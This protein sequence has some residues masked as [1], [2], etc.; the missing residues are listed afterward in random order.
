[1]EAFLL[2]INGMLIVAFAWLVARHK[3]NRAELKHLHTHFYNHVKSNNLKLDD[4]IRRTGK[5][6]KDVHGRITD[7][8]RKAKASTTE[9]QP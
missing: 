6:F 7:E 2:F 3:A 9:N 8:V 4:H 1:M 5:G